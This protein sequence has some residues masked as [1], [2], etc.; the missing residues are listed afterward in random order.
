MFKKIGNDTPQ[1]ITR[2]SSTVTVTLGISDGLLR[3]PDGYYRYYKVIRVHGGT[4]EQLDAK[5]NKTAKTLTFETDRFSTYAV[6]YKDVKSVIPQ[7]GDTSDIFL[8]G[9]I[10]A[11]SLAGIVAMLTFKKRVFYQPKYRK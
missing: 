6:T 10:S 5:V 11:V 1:K 3:V 7:T 8:L 2:L 9:G 4:A